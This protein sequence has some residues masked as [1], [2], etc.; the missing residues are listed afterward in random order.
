M[1]FT[2]TL[3][4]AQIAT[5]IFTLALTGAIAA[6]DPIKLPKASSAFIASTKALTASAD[7]YVQLERATDRL[8]AIRAE[9]TKRLLNA[10]GTSEITLKD[11]I[12]ER[13][14]LCDTRVTHLTTL[15]RLNF[16]NSV[17]SQVDETAKVSKPD[18]VLSALT[19][20]FAKYSIDG[21]T[22]SLDPATLK[23]LGDRTKARCE[24][25]IKGFDLA[26]YGI[27]IKAASA[28]AS[29]PSAE[30]PVPPASALSLLGPL[31]ALIDTFLNIINPVAIGAAT[32][33]DEAKREDAISKFFGDPKNQQ[34][35]RDIG[36]KLGKAASDFNWDKRLQL[37][38]SYVES[39]REIQS[40]KFDLSKFEECKELNS[41]N[42]GRTPSGAPSA[43]FMRCWRKV[44]SQLDST[45]ASTLKAANDYDLLADA[46]DTD[47]A[48]IAFRNVTRDLN[49]IRTN[50]VSDPDVLWMFVTQVVIFATTVQTAFSPDNRD[51]LHKAIDALVKAP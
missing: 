7:E 17:V 3:R 27:E 47:T 40:S 26:Y 19:L 30:A 12:E 50:A 46:G 33:V 32:L 1:E 23:S 13:K 21:T 34:N 45:V 42:L 14:L 4:S 43:A 31:G 44:W 51:K 20:L 41:T 29:L 5:C 9:L 2:R 18:N 38:A 10:T 49:A 11:L 35:L 39:V 22:K 6:D 36:E 37:A 24:K 28:P 8:R 15:A 16:L 48:L 25:D